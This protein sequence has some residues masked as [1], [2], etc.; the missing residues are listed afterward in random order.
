[1]GPFSRDLIQTSGNDVPVRTALVVVGM[2]RARL[3]G[4]DAEAA[5]RQVAALVDK[6]RREGT[7]VV[8]VMHNA[9]AGQ[10]GEPN[11]DGWRMAE[12]LRP[13]FPDWVIEKSQFS[14]FDGTNLAAQLQAVGIGRLI[15]TGPAQADDVGVSCAAATALGFKAHLAEDL[16]DAAVIHQTTGGAEKAECV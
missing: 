10:P 2:Q 8:F 14:I 7:Q 6:T 3:S 9:P 13:Q 12:G 16:I 4:P 15:L 5:T 1:M 11:G